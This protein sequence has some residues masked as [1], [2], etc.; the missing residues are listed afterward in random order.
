MSAIRA[1]GFAEASGLDWKVPTLHDRVQCFF[2]SLGSPTGCRH[3]DYHLQRGTGSFEGLHS[4]WVTD[5][6]LA[7]AR[8]SEDMLDAG[9]AGQFVESGIAAIV[10]L[11]EKGEHPWCGPGIVSSGFSYNPRRFTSLGG[12]TSNSH[13]KPLKLPLHPSAA[14]GQY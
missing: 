7:C 10:N 1:D 3:E 8:P 14:L 11:Q 6:I 2:E 9:L 13:F 12:T 5:A 4:N